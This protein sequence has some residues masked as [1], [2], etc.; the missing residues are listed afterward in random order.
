MIRNLLL[1][2]DGK[3][4]RLAIK[5]VLTDAC[6]IVAEAV[7]GEEALLLARKNQPDLIILDMLLPR[8]GGEQVLRALRQDPVTARIP[9]IVVSSLPECNAKKLKEDGATAYVEKS[10]LCLTGG[11]EILVRVVNAALRQA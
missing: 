7:D 9:V 3:Y 6:F 4:L 2:E 1:V 10:K 11:G 8:L 5:R